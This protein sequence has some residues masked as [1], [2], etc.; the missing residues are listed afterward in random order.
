[1]GNN[2]IARQLIRGGEKKQIFS[3]IPLFEIITW[4]FLAQKRNIEAQHL[5][6][7]WFNIGYFFFFS[8]FEE[9]ISHL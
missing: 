9:V 5:F 1:M 8:N 3:Y 2:F 7:F 6:E 4:D